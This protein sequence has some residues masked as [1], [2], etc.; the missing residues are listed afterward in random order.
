MKKAQGTTHA[1]QQQGNG[2]LG[3][4]AYRAVFAVL[5]LLCAPHAWALDQD[6]A[7]KLCR[8]YLASES[9][10]EGQRRLVR[11]ANYEHEIDPVLQTLRGQVHQP[12]KP[13][14][15]GDE[16]FVSADLRNKHRCQPW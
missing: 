13:G 11:L 4:L 7:V 2:S 14:Y 5:G 6:A 12:V 1:N 16:H 3:P 15:Y 9:R 10:A 8:E